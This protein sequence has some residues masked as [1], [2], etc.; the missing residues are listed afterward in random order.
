MSDYLYGR[1][2]VLEALRAGSVIESIMIARGV[3]T[4]GA[5][6][7][8][9]ALAKSA[10]VPV[11]G[12]ARDELD[13]IARHHQGVVARIGEYTYAEIEEVLAVAPS[14]GEPAF[15]LLLDSVQDP[16]NFGTLLRTAEA[17]GV[18][19]VI[20]AE[21]RAVGVTPT[22]VKASA[23]AAHHLKIARVT[24][25]ARTIE[26]LKRANIWIVGVENVPE[27]QDFS[28]M[29]FKMPLALVLGSE[30]AGLGRLVRE[31]CDFLIR[32]PM[33][34]KVSS[35]NVAVAGSIVLYAARGQRM[36]GD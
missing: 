30:G 9:L 36:T 6:D 26:E 31:K 7:E 12:V 25:L 2:A 32:L 15:L 17:V 5:L 28:R 33:W 10:N 19:G 16:Q 21:R 4:R 29:D 11:R 18:D 8:L 20:I 35:L 34:G 13:R 22:V 27:A 14:R 3:H 24:N 1:H 23:G